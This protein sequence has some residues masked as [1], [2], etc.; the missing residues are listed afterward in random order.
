MLSSDN[1]FHIAHQLRVYAKPMSNIMKIVEI[2]VVKFRYNLLF[3]GQSVSCTTVI[4]G[5]DVQCYLL[6]LLNALLHKALLATQI[7]SKI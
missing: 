7:K 6:V 5:D 3:N 4:S 2:Y 1:F